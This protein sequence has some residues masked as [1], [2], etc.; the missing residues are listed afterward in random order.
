MGEKRGVAR[1]KANR[2]S[3]GNP[4]PRTH[5][6]T[7][8]APTC[9]SRMACPYLLFAQLPNIQ[10]LVPHEPNVETLRPLGRRGENGGRGRGVGQRRSGSRARGV[11]QGETER[12][13]RGTMGKGI[14]RGHS[15]AGGRIPAYNTRAAYGAWGGPAGGRKTS[16]WQYTLVDDSPCADHRGPEQ[17][18]RRGAPFQAF[19]HR[20][21]DGLHQE[22]PQLH[23]G[24]R[25]HSGQ[26]AAATSV[27]SLGSLGSRTLVCWRGENTAETLFDQ[28]YSVCTRWTW[29]K[30]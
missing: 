14:V 22:N 27:P 20:L 30:R 7:H 16:T 26:I 18:A 11:V 24:Q 29:T 12:G 17:R 4:L 13:T 9:P 21:R 10:H 1:G 5:N 15:T 3:L 6:R 2:G 25:R 8:Y 19:S 23:K 28:L